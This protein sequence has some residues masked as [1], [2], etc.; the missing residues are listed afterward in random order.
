MAKWDLIYNGAT[1]I[2]GVDDTDR[3]G[4][5]DTISGTI[6]RGETVWVTT[7]R[8]E[9]VGVVAF[10]VTPGIGA[11]FVTSD[12]EAETAVLRE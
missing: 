8:G 11:V 9:D 5:S 6:K 10:L 4:L 3:V 12:G 7:G 1:L 2:R